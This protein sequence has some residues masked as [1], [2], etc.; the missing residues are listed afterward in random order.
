MARKKKPS[1]YVPPKTVLD[2]IHRLAEANAN[3]SK[4]LF[5]SKWCM[6]NTMGG[7]GYREVYS[8]HYDVFRT[9]AEANKEVDR[10]IDFDLRLAV[11]RNLEKAIVEDFGEKCLDAI[12]KAS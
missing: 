10:L 3:D 8:L 5:I 7:D 1:G 2:E 12:N 11:A 6:E 9:I 4:W